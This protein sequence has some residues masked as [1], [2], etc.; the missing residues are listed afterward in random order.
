MDLAT[1]TL[2]GLTLYQAR[3][4]HN[5]RVKPAIFWA[6]II[7]SIMPDFDIVYRMQG[8]MA[9]LLNHRG[10]THSLPGVFI[11]SALLAYLLHLR[12]KAPWSRMFKWT[13]VA[14]NIHVLLDVL[15]TWGTRILYP[16]SKQWF[17]LDI[18]P[19]WDIPLLLLC[20][21]SL[22]AGYYLPQKSC[23]FAQA[24]ILLFCLYLGGR[25][26]LHHHLM[27]LTMVQYAAAPVQKISVLPTIHPLHWQA[28]LETRSSVTIGD[29][30]IFTGHISYTAWFPTYEDPR[31]SKVRT[32]YTVSQALP[33]FRYPAMSLQQE[34]DKATVVVS[35]LYFGSNDMRRI[36][37]E[38][39]YD[40]TV[41]H[42][43]GSKIRM[44]IFKK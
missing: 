2:V 19:F 4:S 28:V 14:S 43:N 13:L 44:P 29:I 16:F 1:H 22:A 10:I 37:F 33:F 15:N 23:R 35:D 40:G 12:Y 17:A 6:T 3:K 34:A 25:G 31:F 9:Y 24:A 38:I 36:T 41:I 20:I 42:H 30:D 21:F 7:G 5:P 32:D 18:L 27:Q 8:N 11:M 26:L 39:L